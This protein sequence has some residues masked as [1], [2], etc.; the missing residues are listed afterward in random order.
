LASE[1][2][3]AADAGDRAQLWLLGSREF[4]RATVDELKRPAKNSLDPGNADRLRDKLQKQEWKKLRQANKLRRR[5]YRWA[6]RV[7]AIVVFLNFGTMGVY[8]V[9]Q[10][11]R[12]ADA[13]MVA[14]FSAT[15]VEILGIV[16]IIA[17]YLF[18]TDP[19][20]IDRPDQGNSQS[21]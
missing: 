11:G 21:A 14:W 13:V 7:A 15:V 17:Q 10:W 18:H 9:S 5:F 2:D 3:E 16:A 6:V 19:A 12:L 1:V 20:K 8:I 4:E